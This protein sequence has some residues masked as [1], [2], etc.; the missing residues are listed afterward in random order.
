VE[1]K[2]KPTVTAWIEC[3]CCE[4][5][6]KVDVFKKRVNKPEPAE[7]DVTADVKVEKQGRLFKDDKK[8][9]E[10]TRVSKRKKKSKVA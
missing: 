6:L 3:P 1:R 4:S 9:S 7:Y 8:A 10:N 5:E 2:K